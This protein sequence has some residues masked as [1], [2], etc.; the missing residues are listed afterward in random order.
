MLR[1]THHRR[2]LAGVATTAALAATAPAVPAMPIRESG[3]LAGVIPA[4]EPEQVRVVRVHVDEGMDWG[5]AGIGAAVILALV[6]VG[7]GGAHTP[8]TVPGRGRS[9]AQL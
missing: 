1:H 6:L 3:G 9:T 5:D 2:L 7:Y 4:T 8:T